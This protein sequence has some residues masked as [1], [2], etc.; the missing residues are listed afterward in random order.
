MSDVSEKDLIR[1]KSLVK[2]ALIIPR[3]ALTLDCGNCGSRHFAIRVLPQS[4]RGKIVGI[5]CTECKNIFRIDSN[6]WIEGTGEQNLNPPKVQTG[7]K[8]NGQ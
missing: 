1:H 3:M 4:G 2:P 6:A 8:T 5:Q 7:E